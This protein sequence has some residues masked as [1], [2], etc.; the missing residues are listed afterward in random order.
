M[1]KYKKSRYI[2]HRIYKLFRSETIRFKFDSKL[3]KDRY[4]QVVY[5][6]V[7]SS[8]LIRVNPLDQPKEGIISTMLHECLHVLYGSKTE[9]EILKLEKMVY[10]H[11]SDHQRENF[12]ILATRRFKRKYNDGE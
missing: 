10:K 8:W 5:D 11:I 3:K 1:N 9:P 2:L 6:D 12:L 4:G 7:S